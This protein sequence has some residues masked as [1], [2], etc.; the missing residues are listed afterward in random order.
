M[1]ISEAETLLEQVW[2]CFIVFLAGSAGAAAAYTGDY[3]FAFAM[4][5]ALLFIGCFQLDARILKFHKQYIA[6]LE[7]RVAEYEQ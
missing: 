4:S 1:K 7:K 5:L 2:D 3:G 6:Y